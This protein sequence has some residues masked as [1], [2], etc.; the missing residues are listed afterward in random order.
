M[1]KSSIIAY[2]STKAIPLSAISR[3]EDFFGDSDSSTTL[4]EQDAYTKVSWVRRCVDLRANALSS[5]PFAVYRGKAGGDEIEWEYADQ[6]PALLWQTS[7]ALQIYGRAYWMRQRNRYGVDKGFRWLLPTSIAPKF[8]REKG[9]VGFER[10]VKGVRYPLEVEDLVYFWLPPTGAELGPG[11]GWVTTALPAAEIVNA[12]DVMITNY[13]GRGAILTTLLSVQGSPPR[14]ELDRLEVWWKRLLKGVKSAGETVA[15]RAEVEPKVIGTPL[16]QVA[17]EQVVDMARQQIATAAGVP[18]TMLEDA[19][20][21]A[22]AQEHHKSLYSE[23]VVPEA[24]LIEGALNDQVFG[25]QGQTFNMDWQSLDVFQ[26][27]EASRSESLV[28]LTQAGLPV[29]FAMELL[30]F[31]LPNEMTYQ[32]LTDMLEKH[33][34]ENTPPQ[35]RAGVTLPESAPTM[36]NTVRPVSEQPVTR[37]VSDDLDRWLRKSLSSLKAGNV[38]DVPFVSEV[39]PD[40]TAAV[41]HE[42]LSVASTDEEVRAAFVPP[43]RDEYRRGHESYP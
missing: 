24:V 25:P 30:G 10:E 9:L 13:F 41:L 6:L 42:R 27:D 36:P 15:I 17:L 12:A 43:F 21:F 31:D 28:R 3:W 29:E 37:A 22:T 33:K 38:A 14:S 11:D 1:P 20:N 35:L 7:A 40:S 18:Q 32:Q 19:A 39:I 34:A 2:D 23:T 16:D 4:K 26:V 8:D 5:I